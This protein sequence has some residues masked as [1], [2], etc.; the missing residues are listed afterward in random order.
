MSE[1][2]IIDDDQ[3]PS[4]QDESS[5]VAWIK[6]EIK[7]SRD[8]KG[9]AAWVKK[10]EDAY[11]FTAG[12]QWSEED[13]AILKDQG[14]PAIVFNRIGPLI[15][16]IAG[17]QVNN[18]QETKLLPRTMDDGGKAELIQGVISWVRD[19]CDAEDEESEAFVDAAICG[20]GWTETRMDYSD[21]PEGKIVVERG[22]PFEFYWDPRAGRKNLTD[23]SWRARIRRWQDEEVY[24]TWPE[25]KS[26]A[27]GGG[28]LGSPQAEQAGVVNPV[29][30][31][32]K[33]G[34]PVG[35]DSDEDT[36]EV[37]CFE[38][39]EYETEVVV[40][41]G[42]QVEYLTSAQWEKVS[43]RLGEEAKRI[44]HT[45]RSKRVWYRSFIAGDQ[46]LE[47]G[48][49]PIPSMS[50]FRCITYKR[51]H[52]SGRYYGIVEMAMD[53]QMWANKWLSQTL[54]ILNT[55]AK[56]GL[57]VEESAIP[58][59][60]NIRD[61]ET[62]Y[63]APGSITVWATGALS[64]GRVEPKI[65]T[66][67]PTGLEKLLEYA[68]NS[69][70]D[71][72]GL[73]KELLGTADRDQP[74]VLEWQRKQS[75][76]TAL[77]PLFDA[78]RRYYKEQG[79]YLLEMIGRYLPPDKVVRVT[80]SNG[81]AVPFVLADMG[82]IAKYDIVVDQAPNSPNQKMEVWAFLQPTLPA[83]LKMGLPLPVWAELLRYSP[84]PESAV[85]K[86][87][88]GLQEMAQQPPPPDP[89]VIKAEA[90]AQARGQQM[91]MDQQRFAMEAQMAQQ[92]HGMHMQALAAQTQAKV[93]GAEAQIATARARA[94]QPAPKSVN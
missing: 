54:H 46:E 27:M 2:A 25:A 16:A 21:D 51:N 63:A 20:M 59:G 42:G 29:R 33:Q 10:A 40:S 22:D 81:Q 23:A 17:S 3:P 92:E 8:D 35:F 30:D 15:D 49:A 32:Y 83:L 50:A 45:T 73:N 71:V 1:T 11:A 31:A 61:I 9:R 72:T 74:G 86:M 93:I 85:E 18:R 34:D 6:G 19:Q 5:R 80:Q 68:I 56:S 84:L 66:P 79:R 90:D 88:G 26:M 7:R 76:Q 87:I 69:I 64:G 89:H 4:K 52:K 47:T 36:T 91:Q 75:A 57:N 62:R 48:P 65:P 43:E 94:M 37:I 67:L 58:D 13:M 78:L 39:C 28:S 41:L 38:W 53:P 77:A 70:P 24:A 12:D 44:K 60:G 55:G 14:R 82:D